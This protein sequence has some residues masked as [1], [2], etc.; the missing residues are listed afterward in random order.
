MKHVLAALALSL[1]VLASSAATTATATA[2]ATD[3]DD[4]CFNGCS[5]HGQCSDFVCTCDA[6]FYGEDCRHSYVAEGETAM[7]V[8]SAGNGMIR[9]KGFAKMVDAECERQVR[10]IEE[11]QRA[12]GKKGNAATPTKS[13]VIAIGITSKSCGR[14]IAAET[15]YHNLTS[16]L[17]SLSPAVPFYRVDSDKERRVCGALDNAGEPAVKVLACKRRRKKKKKT[18]R[19]KKK[20]LETKT[21]FTYSYDKKHYDGLH[22]SAALF[23]FVEKQAEP[24][25]IP[26]KVEE[27][28]LKFLT[29]KMDASA[30]LTRVAQT[31]V[32]HVILGLFVCRDGDDGEVDD[33]GIFVCCPDAFVFDHSHLLSPLP[34]HTHQY[35]A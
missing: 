6:G 13:A 20:K 4:V 15:E 18:K 28:V 16:H 7:P 2:S 10:E 35:R 5:G 27:D 30:P 1:A 26:F 8:L 11:Q 34:L 21:T 17:A 12:L 25:V 29:G 14:C 32:N 23:S 19:Q 3:A 33:G 9:W 22:T 24:P 31:Q